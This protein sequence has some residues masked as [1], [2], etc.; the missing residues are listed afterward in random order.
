M[1]VLNA[2]LF[3][4]AC[5]LAACQRPAPE[6]AAEAATA[7]PGAAD[8]QEAPI[9]ASAISPPAYT[10]TPALAPPPSDAPT[11]QFVGWYFEKGG[12]GM[13][14]GCGQFVPL[15][16]VDARFLRQ[17]NSRRGG[18]TAPVYV[19]LEVRPGS[20]SKLE[21]AKIQQFGVDEGPAPDCALNLAP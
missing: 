16:V 1:R 6:P 3:V 21:V 13:L 9:S 5:S 17:L 14:V 10:A 19:R 7:A 12:A 20:G 8:A 15:E 4:A 18:S 2:V 11:D